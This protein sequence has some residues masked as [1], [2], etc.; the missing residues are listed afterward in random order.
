MLGQ[1]DLQKD[2]LRASKPVPTEPGSASLRASWRLSSLHEVS[3]ERGT[4]SRKEKQ[5]KIAATSA[6]YKTQK[7]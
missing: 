3:I 2:P 7:S 4:L 1:R 5:S 6:S